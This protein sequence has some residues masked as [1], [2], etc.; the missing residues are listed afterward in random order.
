MTD[1]SSYSDVQNDLVSQES[2][3]MGDEEEGMFDMVTVY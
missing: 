2:K 3:L 1:Y